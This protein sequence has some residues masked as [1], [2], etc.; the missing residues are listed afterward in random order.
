MLLIN[1]VSFVDIYTPHIHI[2]HYI[3]HN[4]LS[5]IF[6]SF[7]KFFLFKL[8]NYKRRLKNLKK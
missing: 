2:N 1:S 3:T 6:P 7:A 4:N 8:L 5:E